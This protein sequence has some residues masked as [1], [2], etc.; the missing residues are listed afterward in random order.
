MA[1]THPRSGR[2]MSIHAP[3][4][5]GFDE[6]ADG[7]ESLERTL[8]AALAARLEV[9][10][11]ESTDACRLIHGDVEG[12]PGITVERFGPAIVLQETPDRC[13]L[14]R[15][16]RRQVGRFFMDR[17][18]AAAVYRKVF[19]KDRTGPDPILEA[20]HRSPEP[21]LGR[22]V[23][24]VIEVHE[25]G[26]DFR[27]RP[28]DGFSVGLFLDHRDN[29]DRV[30][31]L[32]AGKRVLNLFAYTCGFSVAAALGGAE[33]TTSVDLSK[34]H[35]EW[36]KENF[37][38]NG[39]TQDRHLFVASDALDFFARARRQQRRFDFIIMD[40]PTFAR[41]K[42]PRQTFSIT[43]D[44]PELVREALTVLDPGGLL[45]ISTNCRTL[46]AAKLKELA[47]RGAAGRRLHLL[48]SP[49]LPVDFASDPHFAKTL[50]LRAD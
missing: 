2:K 21:M 33:S 48:E 24:P 5:P 6:L 15:A 43:E 9:L 35:L 37:S 46:S 30:R 16:G 44:L 26:R 27:V 28:Y 40:P 1:F 47:Q 17:F 7:G 10:V 42:K 23:E 25:R 8:L 50:F 45:M 4:P 34:A 39:L 19:V 22:P 38:A 41:G 11:D 18:G 13:R 29:R 36:G 14:N 20:E 3:P 12:L 31:G 32:A 49:P